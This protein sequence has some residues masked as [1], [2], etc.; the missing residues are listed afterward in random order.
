MA[1]YTFSPAVVL[2]EGTSTPAINAVGVLRPT[3]GGTAVQVYDLNNSPIPSISVSSLGVHQAFKADI[4]DGVLDFGSV[5][6]PTESVESRRAGQDALV[7]ATAAS[8][9]VAG[10]VDAA[11]AVSAIE[12]DATVNP[13]GL[14]QF[15]QPPRVAGLAL[16]AETVRATINGDLATEDGVVPA[17]DQRYLVG[18]GADPLLRES[19]KP[20]DTSRAS[21]TTI[22]ADPDL[23]LSLEAGHRYRL[24]GLLFIEA[25][26]AGDFKMDFSV[27]SGTVMKWRMLGPN[28]TGVADWTVY[29]ETS[30]AVAGGI[31]QG[32]IFAVRLEGIVDTG[33][34][35]GTLKFRWAQGTSNV[36]ATKLLAGSSIALTDNGPVPTDVGGGVT[37]PPPGGVLLPYTQTWD[38]ASLPSEWLT[39]FYQGGTATVAAGVMTLATGTTNPSAASTYLD[40]MGS[41]ADVVFT[42][43]VTPSANTL[44]TI[45]VGVRG[46]GTFSTTRPADGYWAELFMN[47]AGGSP[48]IAIVRGNGVGAPVTLSALVPFTYA[49]GTAYRV[50]IEAVGSTIRAKIW[51]VAG[52]EPGT[53][54]VSVT[55][56]T[57]TT[58]KA[59]LS[60]MNG[61]AVSR[62]A[63]FDNTNVALS[64]GG[65]GGGGGGTDVPISFNNLAEFQLE[66]NTVRLQTPQQAWSFRAVTDARTVS[67]ATYTRHEMRQADSAI[68]DGRQR[69]EVRYLDP[70]NGGYLPF[71]VDIWVSYA[72]RWSGELPSGGGY[73]IMSQFNQAPDAN[74]ISP[75]HAA[76]FHVEI[77]SGGFTISTRGDTAANSTNDP[78]LTRRY[79]GALPA[80]NT[81]TYMVYRVRLSK[82]TANGQLQAWRNGTEVVNVTNIV[83]AYNDTRGPYFKFGLYRERDAATSILEFA[84]PECSLTTLAA[85]VS[86]PLALPSL[87]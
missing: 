7:A 64:S 63:D 4:M 38:G 32:T 2:I 18:T 42:T 45:M 44:R 65:G 79:T 25:D 40:G 9:A 12:N 30:S 85:R 23:L 34:T 78:G 57:Y 26:P 24:G 58:G 39:N 46:S 69:C 53:W 54:T 48:Y 11:G 22:A 43:D 33:T 19:Y 86:T 1:A 27:P 81:W 82:S 67:G 59:F 75:R 28:A 80:I 17:L 8:A 83:N 70:V 49:G 29:G 56:A 14:W 41:T 71:G 87:A 31:A 16:G 77:T 84:N 66:G 61:G 6:L 15:T 68:N 37:P 13:I 5:L 21:T 20:G 72:F 51:A 10:K 76:V 47:G 3:G 52:S 60:I 73:C 35:D 74:D 62:S 50:K 36:F 55:D